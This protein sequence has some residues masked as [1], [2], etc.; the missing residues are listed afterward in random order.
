VPVPNPVSRGVFNLLFGRR[1]KAL[2]TL[3][4]PEPGLLGTAGDFIGAPPW[5]VCARYA[6][7]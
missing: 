6:R 5:E 1:R 3:P 2:G 7:E 4:G